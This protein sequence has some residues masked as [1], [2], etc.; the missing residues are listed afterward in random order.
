MHH[1]ACFEDVDWDLKVD[2]PRFHFAID[3]FQILDGGGREFFIHVESLVR[4]N[5]IIGAQHRT[6]SAPKEVKGDVIIILEI[7]E[8]LKLHKHK[9][10]TL[11]DGTLNQS[12]GCFAYQ[13][14]E[15]SPN[16]C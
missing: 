12:F 11:I 6:L 13:W 3:Q 9:E 4:D 7:V 2:G 1:E 14:L 16:T 5:E 15:V 8:T 10:V